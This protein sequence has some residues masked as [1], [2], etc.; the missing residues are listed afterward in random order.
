MTDLYSYTNAVNR[1][2]KFIKRKLKDYA[3]YRNYD[4]G[5]Q[6]DNFVSAISPAITRKI[7]TEEFVINRALDSF[8]YNTIGKYIEEVCWRTYWRGYLEQ[9]DD[10]WEQYNNS[11]DELDSW[12]D[13]SDYLKAINGDTQIR[14]FNF[15]INTLKKHNYLHNH[16]R[17]WFAS[18]W[19]H[20]LGL[21]WQLG[22]DFFMR[23]L[24][25]ADSASNTLSWRWVVGL[26][27]KNKYYLARADN[28]K[29][30]TNGIFNPH[31][32]IKKDYVYKIPFI[33]SNF[34]GF[35]I[36]NESFS[37]SVNCVL[38]HEND[39]SLENLPESNFILVQKTN[40]EGIKRSSHVKEFIDK[41]LE[42][43]INDLRIK[44]KS[45]IIEYSFEN[46]IEIIEFIKRNKIEKIHTPYPTIGYLKTHLNHLERRLSIEFDYIYSKWDCLFWPHANKGF[47]KLKKQ[48]PKLLEQCK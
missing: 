33:N 7:V 47:F 25:D 35:T 16:T 22:A 30:Y 26:H 41:C 3:R 36:D 44:S 6:E 24:L 4:Y 27:T 37:E 18:I 14:C 19:V 10:I 39:L 20:Y 9:H 29:K 32:L 45:K 1:L 40:C 48:I 28:I 23:H 38:I 8:K 2:D 13:D 46:Q 5:S 12:R 21:P 11:L 42:N 43:R 34:S 31:E 15:W 17:M